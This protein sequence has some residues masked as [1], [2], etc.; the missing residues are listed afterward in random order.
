[1]GP[2]GSLVSADHLPSA[3]AAV[4]TSITHPR[5]IFPPP[6]SN[7]LRSIVSFSSGATKLVERRG[8]GF[9]EEGCRGRGATE[10]AQTFQARCGGVMSHG[11]WIYLCML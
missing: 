6:L 7:G 3:G 4:L 5:P 1:M 9:G 8:D 2:D 10:A 11:S